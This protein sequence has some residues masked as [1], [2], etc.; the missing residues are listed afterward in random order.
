MATK[1]TREQDK[2]CDR[3]AQILLLYCEAARLD[4]RVAIDGAGLAS[5]AQLVAK[6]SSA[7]DLDAILARALDERGR[8]LGLRQGTAE[9]LTLVDGGVEPLSTLLLSDD[10]FRAEVDR[11]EAELGEV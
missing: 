2:A 7:F 5:F 6:A 1:P 10:D 9:L 3:L 8:G 11:A 4:G